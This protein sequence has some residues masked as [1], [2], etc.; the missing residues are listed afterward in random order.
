MEVA[1][2]TRRH[3]YEYLGIPQGLSD[4]LAPNDREAGW[5]PIR[6]LV[7]VEAPRLIGLRGVYEVTR[8][9]VAADPRFG[10]TVGCDGASEYGLSRCRGGECRSVRN[11]LR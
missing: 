4:A 6:D 1:D 5:T 11:I 9:K 8:R 10:A 7:A 3:R 2:D